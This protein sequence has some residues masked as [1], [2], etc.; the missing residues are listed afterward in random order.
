M[1]LLHTSDWHLGRR[2][3]GED[4]L[5]HQARFLAW[6]LA[7]AR[8]QG[9]G[10]VLVSGDVYDRAQPPAEAVRLLDETLAA[11][12]AARVPLVLSSGNHDSAVRLQYGGA[13]MARAGV[14]VRTS[15]AESVEPVVLDDEHGS[16]GVYGVPFLLPDAVCAELAVSRSHEAVLRAAVERIKADAAERGLA[17]TVVMA[18]AFVTG[19]AVSE[20]ERDIRV[21]GIAD[22]P[23]GVFDGVTYVALGHLHRPQEVR[24]AQSD[25]VLQYSGSPLAFSFSEAGHTKSVT[26]VDLGARGVVATERIATPTPRPLREVTGCLDDLIARASGDLSELASAWVK[27]VLTDPGRVAN[28]MERLRA[29]WPHT[30]ALQF[31]PQRSGDAMPLPRVGESVDPVEIC[32]RFLEAVSGSPATVTQRAIVAEAVATCVIEEAVA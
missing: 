9:V 19:G 15:L 7:T 6:L 21:G 25:T 27:V 24:L 17:R 10:A 4:L 32:A 13:V 29:V 3:H 22:A 16:V 26:L 12:A 11:F 20:S 31:A 2:L 14:H 1:R 28:P 18:H 5:E 8:S 23:A 30:V